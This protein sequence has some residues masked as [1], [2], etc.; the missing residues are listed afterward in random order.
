V[1]ESSRQKVALLEETNELSTITD[2]TPLKDVLMAYHQGNDN[3]VKAQLSQLDEQHARYLRESLATAALE[4][5]RPEILKLCLDG[6]FIYRFYFK[7]AADRVEERGDEPELC[8]VL[9]ESQFRKTRP[10][11]IHRNDV[12][13]R[14]GTEE[15]RNRPAKRNPDGTLHI[16]QIAE[17]DY[18]THW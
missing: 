5:N 12:N 8:K 16:D 17:W 15:E 14:D 13:R 4:D 6:G 18:D 2:I 3:E 9:D 7:R 11:F 10:R 1:S